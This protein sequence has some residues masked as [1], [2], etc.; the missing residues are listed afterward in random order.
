MVGCIFRVRID[1]FM[2]YNKFCWKVVLNTIKYSSNPTGTKYN[3]LAC[4]YEC[5]DDL[6]LLAASNVS[7]NPGFESFAGQ[8]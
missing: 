5:C 6:I 1:L 3:C 7:Q 2:H 8:Y 4:L